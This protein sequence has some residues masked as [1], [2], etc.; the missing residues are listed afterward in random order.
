MR[1]TRTLSAGVRLCSNSLCRQHCL[2]VVKKINDP[3]PYHRERQLGISK[4]QRLAGCASRQTIILWL[5]SLAMCGWEARSHPVFLDQCTY[6]IQGQAGA[7]VSRLILHLWCWQPIRSSA[8]VPPTPLSFQLPTGSL[9]KHWRMI[10][11]LWSLN[12]CRR[13]ERGSLQVWS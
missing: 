3:V 12:P 11:V 4:G 2:L 9:S 8:C 10:L 1:V 5:M 13:H 7:V 6:H